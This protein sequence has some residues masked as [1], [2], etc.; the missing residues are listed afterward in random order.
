ML[1]SFFFMAG[2][3]RSWFVRSFVHLIDLDLRFLSSINN[4]QTKKNKQKNIDRIACIFCQRYGAFFPVL[5][6]RHFQVG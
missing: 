3:D 5:E 1:P 2:P 4:K 6:L